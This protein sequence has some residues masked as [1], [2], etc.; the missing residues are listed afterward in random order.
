[1]L[2]LAVATFKTTTP[3]AFPS[4]G[5]P[6]EA[7]G[8]LIALDV[9]PDVARTPANVTADPAVATI[10]ARRESPEMTIAAAA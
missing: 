3:S 1:M 10:V 2:P 6:T 4:V 7:I 9:F 5:L 8:I